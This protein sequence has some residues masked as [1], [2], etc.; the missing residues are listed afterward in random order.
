MIIEHWDRRPGNTTGLDTKH[1][2]FPDRCDLC[3]PHL[4]GYVSDTLADATT[5]HP[6]RALD[7]KYYNV[8]EPMIAEFRQR[9]GDQQLPVKNDS[10]SVQSMVRDDLFQREQVGVD[11]YGTALQA[12]NG[13][14]SGLDA[15]EEALDLTCYLR[16]MREERVGGLRTLSQIEEL[17][18]AAYRGEVDETQ[19]ASYMGMVAKVRSALGGQ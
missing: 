13:R 5:S 4:T 3:K 6:V 12:F 14:D 18:K 15:Y 19:Y 1:P 11:R 8:A 2:G 7:P 9:P 16:Q 10:A 17:I